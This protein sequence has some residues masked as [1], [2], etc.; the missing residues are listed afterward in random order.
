MF[1][2]GRELSRRFYQEEVRP[3]D[4]PGMLRAQIRDPAVLRIADQYPT[5]G[6][7]QVREILWTPRHRRRTL[8]LFD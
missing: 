4:F 3:G 1:V 6:V 8:G 7:D 2:P 5:G